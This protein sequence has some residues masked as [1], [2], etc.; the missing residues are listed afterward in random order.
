MENKTNNG[1]EN[2]RRL[3]GFGG[4]IAILVA[5]VAGVLVGVFYGQAMWMA[6]GLPKE[7]WEKLDKTREQKIELAT[8][9]EGDAATAE[10]AAA[11]ADEDA[12][13]AAAEGDKT[14]AAS[15]RAEASRLR[16]E[17]EKLRKEGKRLREEHVPKIE[18]R[19]ART[20]ELKVQADDNK[21]AGNDWLARLVW[22]LTKFCGDMFLQ[23]L[24][25]LVIPLVVTSMISGVTSLGDVRKLGRLGGWTLGYYF[26][27]CA[28]A[29]LI[30]I[31]LVLAIRPGQSADDTFSYTPPQ[32]QEKEDAGVLDTLL[33]V[34][35]GKEEGGGMFPKNLFEAASGTNVLGLLV[36]ALFFGGALTT[37]GD[38]GKVA[39][40]FFHGANQAVMKLVH[41]VM[42]VAPIGIYGLVATKIAENG[43]GE[44]FGEELGR[45]TLYAMTVL[46]GLG[47]H[48]VFLAG[49]LPLLARRN[50][51]VYTYNM[52]RSLLTAMSTASSSA[53]LPVT[54]ECVE[55]KNN[56]SNRS[57]GFVLPLGAT[58][59]MDGTALYEAVAVIFIAQ[60]ID[61]DLNLAQLIVIFLTATL[62]AIGAAGIPEAGLVTMVIVLTAAGVPTTGIGTI[63]AID[64]FLDRM[65]TTVNVYGDSIGAAIV[66]ANVVQKTG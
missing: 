58:I 63:L 10:Q 2:G 19:M 16:A 53:S 12:V 59:N 52:L 5:I 42:F 23:V 21:K 60:S 33:D 17:A 37:L 28:V 49:L 61:M 48:V 40:E 47:I 36:F 29:V 46:I 31:V 44:A 13:A 3:G 55:E 27:T 38:K 25:M 66:D 15:R 57:A 32:V 41:L 18:E 62:A 6:A 24:F 39:I 26:S 20:K 65:R 8:Q 30:G 1:A 34:F 56:V 11:K 45:L 7:A 50:P 35:R 54:F 43:G 51:F 22:Q 4:L 14:L 9:A 64:W